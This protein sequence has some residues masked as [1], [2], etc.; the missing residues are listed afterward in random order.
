LV[1]GYYVID[2]GKFDGCNDFEVVLVA[3]AWILGLEVFSR[4]TGWVVRGFMGIPSGKDML[5]ANANNSEG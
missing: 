1:G 3:L 4:V 2:S 5:D